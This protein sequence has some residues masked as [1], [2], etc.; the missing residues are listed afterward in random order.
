MN[1]KRDQIG[2]LTNLLRGSEEP[3]WTRL[4][5]LLREKGLDFARVIVAECFPDDTQF[6]FGIVVNEDGRVFQFGF[7]YL[8]RQVEDGSFSEWEDLTARFRG[9]PHQE[10]ITIGLDMVA[11]ARRGAGQ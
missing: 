11:D 9:T 4:R 3:F 6:E 8:H 5:V 2:Q 10:S 1:A 7:D